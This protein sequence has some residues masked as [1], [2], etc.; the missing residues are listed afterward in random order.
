M[1][2]SKLT[3]GL[4]ASAA[5]QLA[6]KVVQVAP[7][8]TE[9]FVREALRH[10]IDGVGPFPPAAEAAEAQLREQH[11]NVDKA[12]RELIENHVAYAAAE[13]LLTNLGGLIT[14]AIVAPVNI[15]GLTL[16]QS[17]LVA[18]IVHL[19][20]YSL[21]DPRVRNA[22]M[23][24]LLGDEVVT[25]LVKTRRIPATPMALATAPTHDPDLDKLISGVLASELIGRIVGKRMATTVGKRVPLVGGAVGLVA[26]GGSTWK[27]G[28]YARKEFLPRPRMQP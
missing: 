10:A 28:R 7:G 13:G 6:P 5:R 9:S 16:I 14:A 24:S 27:V 25:R 20:G 2:R 15:A 26:D 17:R 21:D 1:A 18:G 8:L 22:I 23:V 4:A 19:R 12:I 3:K 11:G